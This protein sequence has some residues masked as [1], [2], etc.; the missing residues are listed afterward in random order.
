[1]SNWITFVKQWSTK[2]KMTFRDALTNPKCRKD[3][4][5]YKQKKGSGLIDD[6]TS[7]I[8][9]RL[10]LIFGRQDYQPKVRNILAQYGDD[11]ITSATLK[12][13]PLRSAI[14]K[15][16]NILTLGRF[17]QK[18]D[19]SEYDKLFHLSL[20]VHTS[21]GAIISIEKNEVISM[22]VNPHS[23]EHEEFSP[24]G[25]IPQNLTL[26]QLMDNTQEFMKDSF[27]Y[28]SARDNNCQDFVVGILDA[29]DL[30]DA[31]NRA[32]AKQD[33]NELFD[34][35]N[36]LRKFTNTITDI[37]A[38]GNVLTE[39]NGLHIISKSHSRRK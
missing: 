39:G 4:A 5:L 30:G 14:I 11:V 33:I 8:K 10:P 18:L 26:N 19:E 34:D 32:F 12:R 6:F 3:F 36:F 7:G 31:E 21:S 13:T 15:I 17:Q 38:R 28:Y 20:L 22:T 24:I 35:S 23:S 27:F 2:H 29:N 25:Y 37:G 9:K 16:L 1:M